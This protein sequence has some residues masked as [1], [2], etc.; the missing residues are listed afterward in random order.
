MK[1]TFTS[2]PEPGLLKALVWRA[3]L[4]IHKVFQSRKP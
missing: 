3:I 4:Y 2:A 1:Y